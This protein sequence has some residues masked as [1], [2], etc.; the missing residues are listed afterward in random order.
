MCYFFGGTGSLARL[1]HIR[2]W[3]FGTPYLI[4]WLCSKTIEPTAYIMMPPVDAA[5]MACRLLSNQLSIESAAVGAAAPAASSNASSSS[6]DSDDDAAAAV[7]AAAAAAPG[8][9]PRDHTAHAEQ[10]PDPDDGGNHDFPS[11]GH[12]IDRQALQ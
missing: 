12:W 2:R 7:T 11:N 5:C 1:C 9:R 6:D 8:G 4:W 3:L 10:R